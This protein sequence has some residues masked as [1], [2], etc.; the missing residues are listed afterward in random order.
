MADGLVS[1]RWWS[2]QWF[3]VRWSSVRRPGGLEV[4]WW[5]VIRLSSSLDSSRA[6]RGD[7]CVQAGSWNRTSLRSVGFFRKGFSQYFLLV[8]ESDPEMIE[9]SD[10]GEDHSMSCTCL[11]LWN[12]FRVKAHLVLQNSSN[13]LFSGSSGLD[14]TR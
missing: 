8:S 12:I 3:V 1:N 13:N 5:S 6:K 14:A 10:E 2:A 11:V 9:L 7:K 4:R